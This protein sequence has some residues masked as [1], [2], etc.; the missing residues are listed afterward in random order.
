MGP[1]NCFG[2]DEVLGDV[3]GFYRMSGVLFVVFF[4]GTVEYV[5]HHKHH[6]TG[7]IFVHYGY[8]AIDCPQ[9]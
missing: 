2:G 8:N 6:G 1:G 5:G 4:L 7:C 3:F 9:C